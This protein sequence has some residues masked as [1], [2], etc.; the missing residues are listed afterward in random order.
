MIL[1]ITRVTVR[2]GPRRPASPESP[3]RYIQIKNQEVIFDLNHDA[4]LNCGTEI[5]QMLN[6]IHPFEID[7]EDFSKFFTFLIKTKVDEKMACSQFSKSKLPLVM[8]LILESIG[9]WYD[10]VSNVS[11]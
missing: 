7:S 6:E 8:I 1:K 9:S 4:I 5:F 10:E 3:Q 2:I 11:T